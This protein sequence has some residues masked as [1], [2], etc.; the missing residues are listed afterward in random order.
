MRTAMLN[1]ILK[2]FHNNSDYQGITRL[3]SGMDLKKMS[4]VQD[5]T[6]SDDYRKGHFGCFGTTR[7]GK[8]RL[9]ENII[10]Q[11]IRKGYNV[12]VVD[13]KGDHPLFEKIVQV[14]IETGRLQDLMLFT[15]IFPQC[16]I[17]L[18][19][20]AYYYMPEEIVDHVVSGVQAKEEYFINVAY[21]TTLVIVLAHLLF[22]EIAGEKP[23]L[24]IKLIKDRASYPDLVKLREELSAIEHP[25]ALE[26]LSA[27]DQILSSPPD[28]FSKVSS[29]LRTVLTSLTTGSVGKVI[30]TAK[31]NEFIRRFQ[32][33]KGVILVVQTGSML[34]RKA[35]HTVGR[36][37]VSMI[38]SLT[39]RLYASGNKFRPP[40]CVHIDEG[41]NILYLGIDEMFTKGGGAN[42][43][44]HFYTQSIAEM[45]LAVGPEA[46]R[47]ILDNI[48]TWMFMKI[49]CP[50]TA[51]YVED[52]APIVNRFS[53]ILSFGGGI[54]VREI[55]EPMIRAD[56]VLQLKPREF[57]MVSYG[58][59]YKGITANVS[60]PTLKIILPQVAVRETV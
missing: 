22:G 18:D 46:T 58:A 43:W 34:T 51:K 31:S 40:L 5:I 23:R 56:K 2:R 21:E 27:L 53:P 1:S 52:S 33:G 37:L 54:S 25:K 6:L 41:Q 44:L 47:S 60:D 17:K 30:G 3:G 9:M 59:Y 35:S 50:E 42:C 45:E 7:I 10:E 55:D 32:D 36:I 16:S 49:N 28:F 11:D 15:P 24:N 19:P 20:L 29:S 13:P 38:Q 26:I 39:G 4:Q 14:A 57:I 48:N 12:V 8:T